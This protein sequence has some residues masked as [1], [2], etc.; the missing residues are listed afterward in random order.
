VICISRLKLHH[1]IN[2]IAK[3][4]GVVVMKDPG[5][6]S[7]GA[8]FRSTSPSIIRIIH[9]HLHNIPNLFTELMNCHQRA[10]PGLDGLF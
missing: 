5:I 10:V 6:S 1:I 3:L 7:G 8:S 2:R 9:R 4:R